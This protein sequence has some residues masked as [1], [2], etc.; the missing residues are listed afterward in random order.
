LIDS[1]SPQVLQVLKAKNLALSAASTS[2][3]K[4]MPSLSYRK[5]LAAAIDPFG[6]LF[7]AQMV[8]KWQ[9]QV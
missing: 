7:I 4:W 1:H 6:S 2:D 5:S 3:G 9:Q 8:N